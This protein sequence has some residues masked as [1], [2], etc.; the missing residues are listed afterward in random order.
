[1]RLDSCGLQT[2]L[3]HMNHAR[4]V[5]RSE[6]EIR[7]ELPPSSLRNQSYPR[8]LIN[9]VVPASIA[10]VPMPPAPWEAVPFAASLQSALQHFVY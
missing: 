4:R 2:V 8:L 9:H 10:P 3:D 6:I 7:H 1:M 5:A